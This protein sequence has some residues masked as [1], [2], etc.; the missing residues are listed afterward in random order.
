MAT[1]ATAFLS[2]NDEK[3]SLKEAVNKLIRL[4]YLKPEVMATSA[5]EGY[6]IIPPIF[7]KYLVGMGLI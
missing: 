4:G 1:S 7:E 3:E 2:A 5:T 6:R